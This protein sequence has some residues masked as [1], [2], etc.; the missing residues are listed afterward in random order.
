MMRENIENN[1][2]KYTNCSDVGSHLG[3]GCLADSRGGP[4]VFDLLFGTS[5]GYLRRPMLASPAA[6]LDR[7]SRLFGKML[8]ASLL[9]NSNDSRATSCTNHTFNKAS[10]DSQQK[11]Q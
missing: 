4:F 2:P 9:Q 1:Y 10:K 5:G 7:F 6:P 3:A 11:Y 8:G